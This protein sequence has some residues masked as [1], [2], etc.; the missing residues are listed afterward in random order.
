MEKYQST[1]VQETV[2]WELCGYDEY[3]AG[4]QL[5]KQLKKIWAVR[6]KEE[7]EVLQ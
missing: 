6:E 4:Y 1:E 3:I 2:N 7:I 5:Y